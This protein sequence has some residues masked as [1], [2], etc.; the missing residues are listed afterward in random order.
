MEIICGIQWSNTYP[1]LTNHATV[2]CIDARVFAARHGIISENLKCNDE[3]GIK[4]NEWLLT[5][6][7][8]ADDMV[9]FSETRNGLQTGLNKLDEYCSRWGLTVNINKTKCVAFRNG[10]KIG[11]LDRWA[12]RNVQL[13]TMNQLR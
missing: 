10:G 3:V 13:E 11:Q 1:F 2:M 7:L 5:V 12:Y 4:F 8:F 6:L 9:I